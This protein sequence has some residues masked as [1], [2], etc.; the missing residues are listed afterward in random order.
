M[1]LR[2]MERGIRDLLQ[3]NLFYGSP[4]AVTAPSHAVAT[5]PRLIPLIYFN[6]HQFTTFLLVILLL[7]SAFGIIYVT[8]V[9]RNLMGQLEVA[10]AQQIELRNYWS[11]LLLEEGVWTNQSRVEQVAGQQLKMIMPSAK[12]TV[13]VDSF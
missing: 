1:I 8:D 9:N 2:L 6:R 5:F 4:Q 3:L 11:Q 13:F 12:S 10:D 7:L